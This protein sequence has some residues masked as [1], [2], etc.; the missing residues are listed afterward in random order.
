MDHDY[1]K[2]ISGCGLTGIISKKKKRLGGH[3]IK[4]SLCLMTDRGNGLG[5]GFAAYGIYPEFEDCYALHVMYDYAS[6]RM[7]AEEYIKTNYDVERIEE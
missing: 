7:E 5:A 6:S 2:D 3:I 1:E 4:K